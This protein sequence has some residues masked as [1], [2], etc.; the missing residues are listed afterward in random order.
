MNYIYLHD[1]GFIL[2]ATFTEKDE[3]NKLVEV[4][5]WMKIEL[6]CTKPSSA[7]DIIVDF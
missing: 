6:P 3:I 1:K 5:N 2:R 4:H 7:K